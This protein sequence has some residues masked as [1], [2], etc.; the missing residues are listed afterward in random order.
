VFTYH[1]QIIPLLQWFEMEQS[2]MPSVER[3]ATRHDHASAFRFALPAVSGV[4]FQT[5]APAF[6][7]PFFLLPA[8]TDG[9]LANVICIPGD[10][11]II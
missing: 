9:K 3:S 1:P 4:C 7:A 10:R 5:V 8:N 11:L 2:L 6:P